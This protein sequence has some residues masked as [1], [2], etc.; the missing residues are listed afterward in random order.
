VT[1]AQA[2]VAVRVGLGTGKSVYPFFIR[3]TGNFELSLQYI[4]GVPCFASDEARTMLAE[5]FR[6]L[7]WL[8]IQWTGKATAWPNFPVQRLLDDAGWVAFT[9]FAEDV[10]AKLKDGAPA[11]AA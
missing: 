5:R 11:D 1:D 3:N 10:L 8:G 9:V 6:A 7:P 2:S 4:R